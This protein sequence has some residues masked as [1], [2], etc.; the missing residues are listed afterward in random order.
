ML[1]TLEHMSLWGVF[2]TVVCLLENRAPRAGVKM[3]PAVVVRVACCGLEE[4]IC[5]A[6]HG[7]SVLQILVFDSLL[8]DEGGPWTIGDVQFLELGGSFFYSFHCTFVTF[9]FLCHISN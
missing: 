6:E 9:Y 2:I 3:I 7:A 4:F 5:D 1:L 8:K